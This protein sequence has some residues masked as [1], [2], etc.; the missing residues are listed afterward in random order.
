[1]TPN[2]PKYLNDTFWPMI[3]GQLGLVGTIPYVCLFFGIL[4]GACRR[5][6]ESGNVYVRFAAYLFAANA[7]VSSIQSNYPGN[8]SMA[9]M[10]FA[11]AMIPFAFI[12]TEEG[13]DGT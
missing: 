7:A 13:S 2:N 9:M 1:M 12:K 8:N 3:F 5:A 10:T 4:L 11:A 6:K